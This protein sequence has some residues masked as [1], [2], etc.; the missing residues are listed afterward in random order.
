MREAIRQVTPEKGDL[1]QNSGPWLKP[2]HQLS[3]PGHMTDLLHMP[4]SP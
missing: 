1:R 4:I 2:D 3:V